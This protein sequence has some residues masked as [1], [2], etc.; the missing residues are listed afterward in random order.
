MIIQ[1]IQKLKGSEREINTPNWSS[2]R[3]LLKKDNMGFSF[4]ETTIYPNTETR[5]WYKNHVEAVFCV[6]GIGILTDLDTG[7]SH[8]ICPGVLYALDKHERHILHA[9]RKMRMICVF[10]PPC[11]GNETHD[12]DGAYPLISEKV[13]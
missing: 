13:K 3:F 8:N 10:S 12:Q 7:K 1:N 5:M 6:E 11:I 9:L 4:H 2:I